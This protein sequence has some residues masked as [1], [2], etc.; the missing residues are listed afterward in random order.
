MINWPLTALSA[1]EQ[2]WEECTRCKQSHWHFYSKAK[3]Y[4]EW[5]QVKSESET[6]K[7]RK[8]RKKETWK[9]LHI[10]MYPPISIRSID[11]FLLHHVQS[12]RD[13]P[14]DWLERG[15]ERERERTHV[16]LKMLPSRVEY[17][18]TSSIMQIKS[19]ALFNTLEWVQIVF[20]T[21]LNGQV[22]CD[23]V[24]CENTRESVCTDHCYTCD[25]SIV[26]ATVK[27]Q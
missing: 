25:L 26:R 20:V 21:Y 22:Q 2:E 4:C 15:R 18:F 23:L 11:F 13:S 24:D 16:T 3:Y 9:N 6:E 7:R 5:L 17:T 10:V 8:E 27:Y 1:V 14:R 19:V 12:S